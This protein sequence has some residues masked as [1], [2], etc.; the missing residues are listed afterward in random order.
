[1]LYLFMPFVYRLVV[2]DEAISSINLFRT[3]TL[4]WNDITEIRPKN[5]SIVLVNAN[6]DIDVFVNPQIDD[7]PEVIKFI[8]QKRSDLWKLQQTTEFHQGIVESVYLLILGAGF[9]ALIG[10]A[11]FR[12][13]FSADR[14][15]LFLLV[16]AICAVAIWKGLSKIRALSLEN[17][18][19]IVK[20]I[21]WK[22]P[23][24]VRKVESVS[25]E[26]QMNKNQV[27]YP[28]HIRLSNGHQIILENIKEGN[29]ILL[30]ALE[31]WL[32]RYKK[33]IS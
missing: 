9:L 11:I 15:G 25:L 17:E 4:A 33:T 22:Q 3:R 2:S 30:D 32:L 10:L 19:L 21:L 8:Q 18:V 31:Q 24:H 29:P 5:G 12:E 7:Y 6:D 1:M 28:I 20:Y 23:Y 14:I 26:Q 16:C 27:N 13:G